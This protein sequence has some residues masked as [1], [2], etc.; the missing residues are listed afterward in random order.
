MCLEYPKTDRA[1]LS[2]ICSSN[3][4]MNSPE[5]S[6]ILRIKNQLQGDFRLYSLPGILE[7]TK[8]K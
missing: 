1:V 3:V 2:Q 5:I 7:N 6:D 4:D 8:L